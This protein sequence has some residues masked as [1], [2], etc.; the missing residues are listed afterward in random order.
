MNIGAVSNPIQHAKSIK[1]LIDESDDGL[2]AHLHK[3]NY[4]DVSFP[5]KGNPPISEQHSYPAF[6]SMDHNR[7]SRIPKGCQ[8]HS[9]NLS[10]LESS[11]CLTQALPIGSSTD[12]TLLNAVSQYKQP[13]AHME[14][15]ARNQVS[16]PQNL[17][18]RTQGT[19]SSVP[20]MYGNTQN[21][22][23]SGSSHVAPV[24]SLDNM[25]WASF[26]QQNPGMAPDFTNRPPG[27]PETR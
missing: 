10:G 4:A 26:I 13:S 14:H 27:E 5:I 2:Y 11:N 9:S 18:P 20:D 23:S 19:S 16:L 6:A 7:H 21:M 22:A 24:A 1:K 12:G 3:D 15:E 8:L 25:Q 17:L